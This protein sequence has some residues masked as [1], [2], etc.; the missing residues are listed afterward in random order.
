MLIAIKVDL[1]DI[2]LRVL[3]L[4]QR[5]LASAQP[6]VLS[7]AM[8]FGHLDLIMRGLVSYSILEWSGI[9][10]RLTNLPRSVE[11]EPP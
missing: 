10:P 4:L 6:H 7:A 3:D 5:L 2:L 11:P 1:S 8:V 9:A